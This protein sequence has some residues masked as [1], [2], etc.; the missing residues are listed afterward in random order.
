M[1]Y[2]VIWKVWYSEAWFDF[3]TIEEAGKFAEMALTHA[4][5]TKEGEKNPVYATIEIVDPVKVAAE[6]EKEAEL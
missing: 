1:I 4:V 2:R 3:A 5:P 6:K